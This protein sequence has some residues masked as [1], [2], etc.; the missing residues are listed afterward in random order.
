MGV[1]RDR[2]G[3]AELRRPP[4]VDVVEVQARG[5]RVDL[6][7]LAVR[8]GRI[9]YPVEVHVVWLALA[10][11]TPGRVGE[12]VHVRIREGPDDARRHRVPR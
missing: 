4:R 10:E 3:Y 9:E 5:R 1:G 11:Q 7:R 6:D 12:D 2:H 8:A